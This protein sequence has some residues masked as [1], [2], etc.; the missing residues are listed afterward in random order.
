MKA[1]RH[2][3][4][5]IISTFTTQVSTL[6]TISTDTNLTLIKGTAIPVQTWRG[7][8]CSRR[9]KLPGFKTIVT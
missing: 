3:N 8:E 1:T 6:F 9:L 5:G 4:S 7:P 2:I